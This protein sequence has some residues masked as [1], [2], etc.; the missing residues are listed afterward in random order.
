MAQD[1]V[2]GMAVDEKT[3]VA[4]VQYKDQTYYFCSQHCKE[5]FKEHPEKYVERQASD[6][7]HHH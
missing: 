2:C 5:K 3:P 6:R 1:L 7:V 4:T